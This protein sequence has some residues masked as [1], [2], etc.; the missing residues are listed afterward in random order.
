MV[1]ATSSPEMNLLLTSLPA[2]EQRRLLRQLE[3]VSM[4][5]REVLY[6]P[7]QP[8][9]YVYFPTKGCVVSV[10]KVMDDGKCFDS[11]LAG[12]EGVVGGEAVLGVQSALF[13]ATVRL[14]GTAL[15]IEA[16]ALQAEIRRGGQLSELL[17]RYLQF[18]LGMLSQIAGCNCFHPLE[19]HLCSWLLSIHDRIHGNE[20]EITHEVFAQMLG[21]RRVGISQPTIRLK[22][23]GL[24]RNKWGKLTILHRARLESHACVCYQQLTEGYK[25]LLDTAWPYR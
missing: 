6:Q 17:Q 16:Q 25:S 22:R 15:R 1:E 13:A 14:G 20:I 11:G 7:G 23:A 8:M 24:I 2:N 3:D 10:I 21:V 5:A 12:Y 19:R 9:K 18:K 4:R